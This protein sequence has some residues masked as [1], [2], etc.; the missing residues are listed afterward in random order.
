MDGSIRIQTELDTKNANIQLASLQNRMVKTADKISSLR[1]KM[2]AM[3]DMQ[4]P[5]QEYRDLESGIASAEKEMEKMLAQDSKL[6]DVDAKIKKLS[7]SFAEYAEKMKEV[8]GQKVPTEQYAEY[9]KILAG[10]ENK[11]SALYEKQERFLATGGKEDST[12]YKKM[13]YDAEAL[14]RRISG[15]SNAMELIEKRGEAF[16][17]G[18]DTEAYK[19]LSEKYNQVN[20]ELEKQKGIHS[21]IA[22]K[23]AGSVQKV[24]ELKGQMQDLVDEGKAFT[25]GSDSEEYAKMGQQLQYLER[26]MDVMAQKEEMLK[27]KAGSMEKPYA[28]L[29]ARGKDL[30]AVFGKLGGVVKNTTVKAFKTL[31]SVAKGALSRLLK[32]AQ[33][34]Q[35]LFSSMS[36]G[37]KKLLPTML[38]FNMIRKAFRSLVSEMKE[39][40]T[41]LY[42]ANGRFKSS[43]DGLKASMLT[44]KNSFAAAFSPLIE[45]VIPYIQLAIGYIVRLMDAVGQFMAAITGQKS[46]TKAIKQTTAALEDESK[47]SNRQLSSLDKLNNSSSGGGSGGSADSSAGMFEEVPIESKWK[48]LADSLHEMWENADFSDLGK[49]IGT[50]IKNALDGI[51]WNGIKESAR[52]IAS[53]IATLINGFV[54]TDGLGYS[55]GNTLA[56][57][58]NTG[59]EF[60]NSFVHKFDWKSAGS[61]VANQLNGLFDGIDWELIYDTFVTGVHGLSESINEFI[62]TFE[63]DNVSTSISWA[64]RTIADSLTEFFTTTKFKELGTRIGEQF[65]RLLKDDKMWYSVGKAIGSGLQAAFDFVKGFLSGIH[66]E[67]V[68]NAIKNVLE[69]LFEHFDD[70]GTLAVIIVGGIAAKMI[71]KS[72]VSMF[73]GAATAVGNSFASALSTYAL[74]TILAAVGGWNIGNALGRIMFGDEA[75]DDFTWSGFFDALNWEDWCGAVHEVNEELREFFGLPTDESRKEYESFAET[76]GLA[77]DRILEM[78]GAMANGALSILDNANIASD[79]MNQTAQQ[80]ET[81]SARVS[82]TWWTASEETGEAMNQTV[83]QA[84]SSSETISDTWFI[85]SEETANSLENLS[86]QTQLYFADTY[87]SVLST[88]RSFLETLKRYLKNMPTVNASAVLGGSAAVL[89]KTSTYGASPAIMSLSTKEIPGYATGQVIP[90]TMKKHLAYLGDN[91]QETEVVSPLSTIK[92]AMREEIGNLGA[93]EREINLNLTVECEGFQL[94]RLMQKLD[95][96]YFKQTGKHA[97]A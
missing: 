28:V 67:D 76:T 31:G 25:L 20:A 26:D 63:W 14:E 46:Y 62:S 97:L 77:R 79:A 69:G 84:Q 10:A 3:K 42:D 36:V 39:G 7:Q 47:A 86:S 32:P 45:T 40:F 54:Q 5:T 50:K 96:Q 35:E 12:V 19:N 88:T 72:T 74:P 44:L 78:S 64:V 43:V 4:T 81:D 73:S 49:T 87:D 22:Q 82:D 37:I 11:L 66:F 60:L 61:F 13:A 93:R 24:I 15:I 71:L 85:A 94:L 68:V 16:K 6:A 89:P 65:E 48:N 92:Q 23:Q 91:N 83:Q 90:R 59:F 80:A 30:I 29:K 58:I 56:Q 2:D 52:N 57:G 70:A 51:N 34:S 1:S 21:E 55:I 38:I 18:A 17:S 8:A 53:S 9:E 33:K 27:T 41:N 75:Y 95:R